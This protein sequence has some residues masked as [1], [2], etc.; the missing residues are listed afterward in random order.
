LGGLKG[1]GPSIASGV[2]SPSQHLT[3][4]RR[5]RCRPAALRAAR[6]LRWGSAPT[7]CCCWKSLP[8]RSRAAACRRSASRRS[9]S[10][11]CGCQPSALQA[12]TCGRGC[13]AEEAPPT[14][15]GLI[16]TPHRP[17]APTGP[18]LLPDRVPRGAAGRGHG[19]RRHPR[20]HAVCAGGARR[21]RGRRALHGRS[22]RGARRVAVVRT[23]R[24]RRQRARGLAAGAGAGGAV[25]GAGRPPAAG[26]RHAR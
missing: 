24:W 26:D 23:A 25:C 7:S 18:P 10:S 2:A 13:A 22:R 5:C 6:P 16:L 1:Q 14:A 21:R 19:L 17:H 9:C 20:P 3:C 12:T 4:H 11:G 15:Q 8:R